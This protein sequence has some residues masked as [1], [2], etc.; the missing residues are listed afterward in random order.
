MPASCLAFSCSVDV[1]Y[2]LTRSGRADPWPRIGAIMRPPG[3]AR[4]AYTP[5]LR[6]NDSSGGEAST[7]NWRYIA[8]ESAIGP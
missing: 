7:W 1:D 4:A 8:D 6:G 2:P 5:S 3:L